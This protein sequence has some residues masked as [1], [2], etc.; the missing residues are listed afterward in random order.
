MRHTTKRKGTERT[1]SLKN[2]YPPGP[3]T[4]RAKLSVQIGIWQ[5][6]AHFWGS[7][8]F[9]L[10]ENQKRLHVGTRAPA[11]EPPPSDPLKIMKHRHTCK[12]KTMNRPAYL[13]CDHSISQEPAAEHL[14]T[15]GVSGRWM[16]IF[17]CKRYL[18]TAF[19]FLLIP[20]SG[21][22]I[23]CSGSAFHECN[24]IKR[25]KSISLHTV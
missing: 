5:C 2:V 23:V 9:I 22:Q 24:H 21:R 3:Q 6:A 20:C 16:K 7:Q 10:W 25:Q 18:E 13:T 15:P 1:S 8:H 14:Q 12:D 17:Y 11:Q 19:P 4:R